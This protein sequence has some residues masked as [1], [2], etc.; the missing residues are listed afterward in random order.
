MERSSGQ[1]FELLTMNGGTPNL[2]PT[3]EG[4]AS[5]RITELFQRGTTQVSLIKEPN[6]R[7]T[8]ELPIGYTVFNNLIYSVKTAAVL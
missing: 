7:L 6:P 2:S 3:G 8:A 1:W 4:I 5:Y